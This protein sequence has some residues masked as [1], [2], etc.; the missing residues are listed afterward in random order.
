MEEGSSTALKKNGE[1]CRQKNDGENDED[2]EESDS[3]SQDANDGFQL[4]AKGE[5][6]RI[7]EKNM[8]ELKLI[9]GDLEIKKLTDRAP[10]PAVKKP[11]TKKKSDDKPVERRVS[12]RNKVNH[13][14]IDNG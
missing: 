2:G 10:K 5:Y 4:Y 14:D 3:E 12:M 1:E 7:R 8:A 9:L 11:V 6:N 13:E